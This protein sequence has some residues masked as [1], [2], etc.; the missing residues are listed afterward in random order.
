MPERLTSVRIPAYRSRLRVIALV[1]GAL[2]LLW[3]SLE[4][5][6]VLPVSLL[7]SGLALLVMILWVTRRFGGRTFAS[8]D[9]LLGAAVVGAITGLIAAVASAALMLV[10]DGLHSDLYPDY[11]FGLIMDTLARAPLWALAGLFAGIGALLA[12]WA[13]QENKSINAKTKR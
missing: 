12:W 8:R 13:L 11:P 9:A 6:S 5:N 2:L 4:D 7:G 3:S 1:Y 10:K